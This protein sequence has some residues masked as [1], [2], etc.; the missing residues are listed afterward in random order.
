M[1]N[2]KDLPYGKYKKNKKEEEKIILWARINK[3]IHPKVT[4]K[5][6]SIS[7]CIPAENINKLKSP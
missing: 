4:H 5:T 2:S 3:L 6:S 1:V 7:L